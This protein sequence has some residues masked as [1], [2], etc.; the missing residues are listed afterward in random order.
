MYLAQGRYAEAEALHKRALAIREKALGP[1]HADVAL[2]LNNLAALYV[3]QGRYAEAEPLYKR[4]L[5]IQEKALGPD[6]PDVGTSLNNLAGL[7]TAQGRYGEAEV[8]EKR[9]LAIQEKALGP[10]HLDVGASLSNLAGL[11]LAQGRFAEAEPLSKRSLA[12]K[13]KALGS[14]HADVAQSFNNLAALYVAQGRYAEAEPL[15]KRALAIDE[16]SLGWRE[17]QGAPNMEIVYHYTDT[18]RLPWILE[19]G[20]LDQCANN[21]GDYPEPSFLWA[22][23]DSRNCKTASSCCGSAKVAYRDGKIRLVRFLLP[24]DAFMKWPEAQEKFPA[25]TAEHVK[26]LETAAWLKA[27]FPHDNFP[28]P[29]RSRRTSLKPHCAC[30]ALTRCTMLVRRSVSP[31]PQLVRLLR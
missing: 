9:S 30:V 13:E 16:K 21:V 11:Y 19:D 6:H 17:H 24:A 1:D 18:S 12:I 27:E 22:T 14:D 4:S 3:A 28:A 15:Y 10:D 20:Y 7:Y 31:A 29:E 23:T 5:A 26:R 8:L 25:W 2:S